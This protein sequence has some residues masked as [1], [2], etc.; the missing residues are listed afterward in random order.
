MDSGDG[1]EAG[2]ESGPVF[3]KHLG[4]MDGASWGLGVSTAWESHL[5]AGNPPAGGL[6]G[7]QGR[8]AGGRMLQG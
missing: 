3:P 5:S 7:G 4:Q 8:V 1:G 2:S 6:G